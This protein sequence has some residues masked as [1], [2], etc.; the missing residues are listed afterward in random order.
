MT[1]I[2]NMSKVFKQ[3]EFSKKEF[4]VIIFFL[5]VFITG[6]GLK[7]ARDNHW[8]LEPTE[9][10]STIQANAGYRIDINKAD[11]YELMLLPGIGKTR[12]KAIIDYRSKYGS[13]NSVDELLN[14]D[15]VGES[16]LNSVRNVVIIKA[17]SAQS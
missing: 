17:L 10:I 14:I 6:T 7:Y 1:I 2:I 13:F 4:V 12:A 5:I 11:R 16:T 15:G 8:H 9:V 3:V